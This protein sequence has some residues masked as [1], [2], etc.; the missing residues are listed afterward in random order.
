[1][2]VCVPERKPRHVQPASL[3]ERPSRLDAHDDLG[4]EI[5][6]LEVVRDTG[7]A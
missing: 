3:T 2:I 6:V 4:T 7:S 1:V 5:T